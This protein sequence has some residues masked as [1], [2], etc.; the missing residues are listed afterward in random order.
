MALG[1]RE[2]QM[3]PYL[4]EHVSCPVQRTIDPTLLLTAD[5]YEPITAASQERDKYLLLY[6]RRYS[7]EMEEYAEKLSKENGWTIIDISLRAINTERGHKMAYDAGVEEFLSLV[8]HAEFVVTNSFHGMIFAVQFQR[9][10]VIFSREQCNNKIDELLHLLGLEE[11]KLI[12]GNIFL[13]GINYRKVPK[14]IEESQKQSLDF[15][16]NGLKMLS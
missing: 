3:I 4:K 10:F 9:P 13:S 8:K 1:I 5:D 7:P 11:R 15:L 14:R 2:N 6:S 16:K 12:S